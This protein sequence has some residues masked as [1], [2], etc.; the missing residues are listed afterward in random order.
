MTSNIDPDAINPNV[1]V[2]NSDNP[3]Q[4]LRDN[5]A[6]IRTQL[7][8]ARTELNSAQNLT[9]RLGGTG[10]VQSDAVT[11]TSDPSGTLV[12]TR[13]RSTDLAYTFDVPGT[14]ALKLPVGR[15]AQ[16]PS[17]AP[18]GSSRGMI[19]YNTDLETIEFYQ[20]TKWVSLQ[21][22]TGATGPGMGNPGPTGASGVGPTGPTGHTGAPGSATNTGATGA[23]GIQGPT[24]VPGSATNT[25]ATG[26]TGAQGPAGPAGGPTGP[27]GPTGTTKPAGPDQSVQYNNAGTLAGNSAVR[28]DGTKLIADKILI[29][30]V[31]INNDTVTNI[32]NQ[33]VLNLNAKGQVNSISIRNSG[34]GYTS[35]P[36]ITIDPPSGAG[37]QA[38]AEARMG[39]VMAFPYNR[40][41]GYDVGDI[42][43]V[44]GGM[45]VTP[46]YL[47]VDT[48]RIGSALVDPD[49]KGIG[50]KPNDVLTVAG[51]SSLGPAPATII[52]TGVGLILPEIIQGG[53]GYQDDQVV[54]VFGG[55][56]T[57]IATYTLKADPIILNLSFGA[58]V[59]TTQY[60]TGLLLR[61]DQLNNLVVTVAGSKQN[62]VSD[63]TFTVIS[64]ITHV[65]FFTAQLPQTVRIVLGGAVTKIVEYQEL[66]SISINN[67]GGFYTVGDVL[68]IG[69]G[70]VI[71]DTTA[72]TFLAG[73]QAQLIVKTVSSGAIV[74]FEPINMA[75]I[76]SALPTKVAT[77]SNTVNLSLDG[78]SGNSARVNVSWRPTRNGNYTQ[79]PS[80]QANTLMGGTGN[81]LIVRFD[82]EISQTTIQR[83]G[84][85]QI[86]PQMTKNPVKNGSGTL[87]LF[88]LTSEIDS[89][90]IADTGYYSI[91]PTTTENPV[92]KTGSPGGTGASVNLSYGIVSCELINPGSLYEQ[93]P[94]VTVT[95]SPSRNNA[96]LQA[97]MTG[98]KVSIGDLLV[99][100]SAV[101]TA[102]VVTNVI[103]VTQDGNDANDGLSEDRAKR[104]VK[105][106]AAIAKPFTTIF[107]RAGNYY[108]N[109]PIYLPERVGVIGD[110]L[111]RVNL[112]YNNPEKDFFWVNNAV[113]IAG[114]SFRGGK[115]PSYAIAFP[116]LS[117]P[118][119]PP[120]IEGGAGTITTSPYVQNCT[121]FNTTG[122]GMK[123]DGNLAHGLK[124]MVLDSYTQFNQGGPGIH[125]TNQG[126]AQLVSIFTICCS[127]GT[128]VETGGNCSISN[129]NT[130][131]GDLG[132][133]AD[134]TSPWLFGGN[135]KAGTARNRVN[136]VVVD[137]INNRPYVG[138][139]ASIA[140]EFCYVDRIIVVDQGHG[141]VAEPSVMVDPPIGYAGQQAQVSA[142]S[143]SAPTGTIASPLQINNSGQYYTGGAS[144]TIHDVS[145]ENAVI[146]QLVYT[147]NAVNPVEILEGGAGY[148][149]N[150]LI[151]VEGGVFADINSE[152]PVILTVLTV[153]VNGSVTGVLLDGTQGSSRGEYDIL[154]IVSGAPTTTT[155]TGNGF[156]CSLNFGIKE[157]SLADGGQGYYSPIFTVSGGGA[158]TAKAKV[159][160]HMES[161]SISSVS[162]IS[163]GN[164]Y[165][166]QPIVN[167]QGGGGLGASA[168]SE[169]VNGAVSSIRITNP[170]ENYS[171]TPSITFSGSNGGGASVSIVYFKAVY[172]TVNS[173]DVVITDSPLVTDTYTNGGIGYQVNDILTIVGG[174]GQP[175]KLRVTATGVNGTVLQVAI[176]Q[177]GRYSVIPSIT[178]APTTVS[179]AGGSGCTID[180][181]LGLDSISV[182]D[183]GSGYISG[184]QVRFAG[185]GAQSLVVSTGRSFWNGVTCVLPGSSPL[186]VLADSQQTILRNMVIEL[187]TWTT[188]I[189]A[190]TALTIPVG[191]PTQ[192]TTPIV[193]PIYQTLSNNITNCLWNTIASF[194]N[195]TTAPYYAP[196]NGATLAPYDNARSLLQVNKAFLQAEIRQYV[197]NTYPGVFSAQQLIELVQNI[198]ILVDAV[199]I[200]LSVAGYVKTIQACHVFWN[201]GTTLIPGQQTQVKNVIS[202]LKSLAAQVIQKQA[203][204]PL[205][206]LVV[207]VI[208]L[209]YTGGIRALENS[210]TAW[211]IV[212]YTIDTGLSIQDLQNGS[213][214]IRENKQLL[215]ALA[216][217][218]ASVQVGLTIDLLDIARLA[219]TMID[220]IAG[221]VI[222]NGG[223]P[224]IAQAILY[225]RYYTVESS[226]PLID[227]GLAHTPG[228]TSNESLGFDIGKSYTLLG[229]SSPQK[230]ATIAA[231][232]YARDWC[233]NLIQNN[234]NAPAGYPGSP[235]QTSVSPQSDASLTNGISAAL[236][237]TT[238]FDNITT[239]I[240][241]SNNSAQ[242]ALYDDV[243]TRLQTNRTSLR[244]SVI[245]WINSTYPLLTY[246]QTKCSRDIGYVI[247]AIS[248]DL[249][250]GGIAHSLKA[251]RAYWNGMVSKLPGA[252]S[253]PT[254][255]AFDQLETLMRGA[256]ILAQS[257]TRIPLINNAL[258]L[259]VD[260]INEI[261]ANGPEL[262]GFN[263]AS[264]LIRL[265]KAF[266]QAELT[267]YIITTY[268]GTFSSAELQSFTQK[269][270]Q[271]VDAV[272]G[273]LVGSGA[274]ALGYIVDKETIVTL[275]ESLEFCPLD[276]ETVNFYQVSMASASS[277]TFEYVGSGTDINTCLPKL[278]GV[279][280]QSNEV[281]MRKG[282]K[283][284]YTSTDHKGDFRIGNGLVINQNSGTLTGRVFN[285]SVLGIIT[286]FVLSIETT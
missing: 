150:D 64:S 90:A 231:I 144:V 194:Y 271:V 269:I 3:S 108:E 55:N 54:E 142:S 105:A 49:N 73:M 273:D 31:E 165:K 284:Y 207:Q 134:G 114:V 92:I 187:R 95:A 202:F 223:S 285:K 275:E 208:P 130:S 199:A 217:N 220:S 101:G 94:Q 122:G 171:F 224:A 42:L 47:R 72:G 153:D 227:T 157:V 274:Y 152:T 38:Q 133:V 136:N 6:Q 243:N 27:A 75:G 9:L 102:P 240:A 229:L 219:G 141:Y 177:P 103:Y 251:G 272:A 43:Q 2:A 51:D 121:C 30:Q 235:F 119:L 245:S 160:F 81:G 46:T 193:N 158:S 212:N 232:N 216:V 196:Y 277:H 87:A 80:L 120:G 16:R 126:Y 104:T 159:D 112:Y 242:Q 39:A 45:A 278:G 63:Y 62:Y 265:N 113:Y 146:E 22:I 41:T 65:V 107:I 286:P 203:V 183:G 259:V 247:D 262:S 12:V 145:G 190:G 195:F 175:I 106:A 156:T 29:D 214:L 228:M 191:Y 115:Y 93:T 172:A 143:I 76:Y 174:T 57:E 234:T 99:T 71:G 91:V 225:P 59:A 111:R 264:Q 132:I 230:T 281:V 7:E 209:G 86:L 260:I 226:S 256:T 263:S 162:M 36:A 200:D 255:L 10:P 149:V 139:V 282:G 161:G 184:P 250:H 131:F 15:T 283:V 110:N 97:E 140:D 239:Y 68:T 48:V 188:S 279:P 50:Y 237:V 268:S 128:W 276:Y 168:V 25:G 21:G 60:S 233:L 198:G 204:S 56:G 26:A 123:V 13:F 17:N 98:A 1:P 67:A 82:T 89:L 138:L 78:G 222:G 166:S 137:G 205:Q 179:P 176:L 244:T 127:I 197:T 192:I 154:P 88:N 23:T 34:G 33:G 125:I 70:A 24:G 18:V 170:G 52:V 267:Q 8:I 37:V 182:A 100:G 129:S 201:D 270:A 258:T 28:F 246:D 211:D 155:G 124:S 238:F 116:P 210:N 118:D 249:Q 213:Q 117:D 32:L 61:F 218:W 35:V 167:I 40:G 53:W 147:V 19:R 173:V 79:P 135:V 215:Q 253:L 163:Q 189:T 74:D 5:F 180:L 11:L 148:S 248:Y 261:I 252:Q 280:V 266:L 178:A 236:A 77:G 96:R 14:S 58:G 84:P 20:G 83:Q 44:Q 109:N 151:T 206:S 185:G 221:D 85:Y 164:G 4:E 254:Q 66:A 257:P 181:S 186:T 241:A 169:V 69:G